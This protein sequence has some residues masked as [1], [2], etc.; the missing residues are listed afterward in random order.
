MSNRKVYYVCSLDKN[1]EKNVDFTKTYTYNDLLKINVKFYLNFSDAPIN[2]IENE[3]MKFKKIYDIIFEY[4]EYK[5]KELKNYKLFVSKYYILRKDLKTKL[6]K[7]VKLSDI[8][9]SVKSFYD[10]DTE[11]ADLLENDDVDELYNTLKNAGILFGIKTS[12]NVKNCLKE[13]EKRIE[14]DT[15]FLMLFNGENSTCNYDIHIMK[16]DKSVYKDFIKNGYKQYVSDTPT[17]LGYVYENG[18]DK[19]LNTILFYT[20]KLG[21]LV[22]ITKNQ[23]TTGNI[24][25]KIKNDELIITKYR[26]YL[27]YVDSNDVV[28]YYPISAKNLK[29]SYLKEDGT[30]EKGSIFVGGDDEE[31]CWF[32]VD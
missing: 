13:I 27:F 9:N 21:S 25:E 22:C 7:F 11:Y 31:I 5:E 1:V 26:S 24:L 2:T 15:I 29:N 17:E 20:M 30:V 32:D 19:L 23:I 14:N 4:E 6:F 3:S 10:N 18:Y 16:K 12:D 28:D 8:E